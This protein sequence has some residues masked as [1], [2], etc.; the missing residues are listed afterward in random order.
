MMC[1]GDPIGV[2]ARGRLGHA[3]R[4]IPEWCDAA[5]DDWA[6]ADYVD[7]M[8]RQVAGGSEVIDGE[9]C[10]CGAVRCQEDPP[11]GWPPGHEDRAWRVIHHLR[12]DRPQHH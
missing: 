12:R 5:V 4:L 9:A 8:T 10:R 11:D 7:S 3:R 2:D 1:V 6:N